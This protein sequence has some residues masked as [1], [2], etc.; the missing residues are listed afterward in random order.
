MRRS[1]P[2]RARTRSRSSRVSSAIRRLRPANLLY[3]GNNP[4]IGAAAADVAAHRLAHVIVGRAPRLVEHGDRG[5]DL[6]R[7]A[8]A[9]LKT[10][11]G[12][13]C[14]LHRVERL[15]RRE[16]LDRRYAA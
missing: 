3:R 5:H 12:D 9:A 13:E 4:G 15:A 16:P 14:P 8:V 6:A 7:R 1:A 11:V 2:W 10:V